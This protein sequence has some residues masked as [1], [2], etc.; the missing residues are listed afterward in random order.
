[1]D[2]STTQLTANVMQAAIAPVFLISAVAVI[3]SCMMLRY[4][5]V[6]DRTRSLLR[7]GDLLFGQ[8]RPSEHTHQE[9][10]S[11]YRRAR[12]LRTTIV[13]ASL[14]IFFVVLAIFF[15]FIDLMFQQGLPHAPEISFLFSLIVLLVSMGLFIED[16]VISLDTLKEDIKLRGNVDIV[17]N[18]SKPL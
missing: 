14:S 2:I 3:L 4:G 7:E 8:K 9:I 12:I 18:S 16:F 17:D 15:L 13:L 6:I 5:R 1:M 11:L 10:R